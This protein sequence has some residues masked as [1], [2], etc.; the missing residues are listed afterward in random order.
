VLF[1]GENT[2]LNTDVLVL[3]SGFIPIRITTARD[4]VCLLTADK[5]VPVL[6][7]DRFVRSPSISIRIPSVISILGYNDLPK[8]KV[9]FSK[10]NI[11][12]RDDMICQF[13]HKRFSVKD[14]TVDHV[15][16]GSRWHEIT[17]KSLSNGYST[18]Q[19]MV[20]ACK[21]C[22]NKKGN[23]LLKELGWSLRINPVEPDYMPHI[24]LSFEKAQN[25]GWLPFCGFNVKLIK[26]IA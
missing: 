2:M 18:W 3:N 15:I 17:G 10:L 26:L 13:C 4:A 14:L 25:R 6:E 16:P 21:W 9:V 1:E 8:R 19:N 12:Y 24:I 7:S 5:A 11:I 22:N 20:C 23:R